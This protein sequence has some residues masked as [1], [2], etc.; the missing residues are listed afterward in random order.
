METDRGDVLRCE[1]RRKRTSWT[2]CLRSRS[3]LIA[4]ESPHQKSA[5]LV[6][7][8]REREIEGGDGQLA[9]RHLGR[10]QELLKEIHSPPLSALSK[11]TRPRILTEFFFIFKTVIRN[12]C[13]DVEERCTFRT[14]EMMGFSCSISKY[15]GSMT[16]SSDL[17][18]TYLWQK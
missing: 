17:P 13:I 3:S 2:M 15:V 10:T 4:A 18:C 9:S 6:K 1:G 11:S 8:E 14:R 12:N 7:K 5:E 16:S